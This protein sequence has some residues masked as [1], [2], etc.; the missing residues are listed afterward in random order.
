M[1]SRTI[2]FDRPIDLAASTHRYTR[3]GCDPVNVV[4]GQSYARVTPAGTAYRATQSGPSGLLVEITAGT[5]ADAEADIRHR[6]SDALPLPNDA[7]LA[8]PG[9]ASAFARMPGYRPP[10]VA[11]PFEAVITSVTAQQVNLTWATTIRRRLVHNYGT[12]HRIAGTEVWAFPHADQLATATVA[13]LRRLQFTTAKA[14]S[15]ITVAEAATDGF[16][17]GLACEPDDVVVRIAT[18]LFG[19]GRW[20]ADWLLA[21]CFGRGHVVAAGD[22]AVRKAVTEFIADTDTLLSESAVRETVAPWQEGT[23]W[24]IHLLLERWARR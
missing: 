2:T 8:H 5:V 23:N 19:V 11:S 13:D 7:A 3:W 1:L 10:L 4:A 20:T 6:F 21:R 16:F 9:V 18:T 22:L 17:D 24:A 14:R 12:L 15:V